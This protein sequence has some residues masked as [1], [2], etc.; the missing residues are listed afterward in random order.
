VFS[1][2]V[3]FV[4]HTQY[5]I[6]GGKFLPELGN[7]TGGIFLSLGRMSTVKIRAGSPFHNTPSRIGPESAGF[8]A[9]KRML[10]GAL[11][12]HPTSAFIKTFGF[13]HLGLS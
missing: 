8:E 5:K 7:L 13:L 11:G 2:Q 3:S 9:E 1:S 4:M 6:P 12:D 10:E